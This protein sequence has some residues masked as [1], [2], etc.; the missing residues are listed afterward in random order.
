MRYITQVLDLL[1]AGGHWSIE[2]REERAAD[3]YVRSQTEMRRLVW[4]QPLVKHSFHKNAF[5]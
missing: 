1:I 3:W 5:G 2:P 4:S